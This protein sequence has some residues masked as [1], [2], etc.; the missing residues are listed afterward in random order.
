MQDPDISIRRRALELVFALMNHSTVRALMREVLAFLDVADSEFKA[1]MCS[2]I[3]TNA[4]RC[5]AVCPTF[6]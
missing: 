6:S 3:A 4:A 5:V 2:S 1:Y